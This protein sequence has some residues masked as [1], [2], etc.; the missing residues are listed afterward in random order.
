LASP[1]VQGTNGHLLQSRLIRPLR[2]SGQS[3][4]DEE[5]NQSEEE[6]L[7]FLGSTI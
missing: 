4:G 5:L 2:R 6:P 1:I 3:I 7:L